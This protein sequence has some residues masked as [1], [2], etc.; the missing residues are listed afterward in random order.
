VAC[1]LDTGYSSRC[2]PGKQIA[3]GATD[4]TRASGVTEETSLATNAQEWLEEPGKDG[5]GGGKAGWLEVAGHHDVCLFHSWRGLVVVVGRAVAGVGGGPWSLVFVVG[6]G[7]RTQF[8]DPITKTFA[9]HD[10]HLEAPKDRSTGPNTGQTRVILV[11]NVGDMS[12]RHVLCRDMSPKNSVL[13][14]LQRHLRDRRLPVTCLAL[15]CDVTK[16]L[17]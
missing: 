12:P 7:V 6:V 2:H 8:M 15:S 1:L 11:G 16:S 4:G 5:D 13:L 17:V 3:I 14:G 9:F 10:F